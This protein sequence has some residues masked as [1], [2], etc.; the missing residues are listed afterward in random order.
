[1][2]TSNTFYAAGSVITSGKGDGNYFI[3]TNGGVTGDQQDPAAWPDP[4]GHSGEHSTFIPTDTVR[5]NDL[6][7]RYA[8]TAAP[9]VSDKP[10]LWK[11]QALYSLG[12]VIYDPPNASYYMVIAVGKDATQTS[13]RSGT[14]LPNF[15]VPP[16]ATI[17]ENSSASRQ[18]TIMWTDVGAIAPSAVANE[19]PSDQTLSLLNLQ[20]PQVHSLSYY[21]LATGVVIST[22]T[23]RSYGPVGTGATVGT[24]SASPLIE[25]ILMLTVYVHK[26]DAERPHELADLVPAPT[27]GLSL[28]S[29][30]SNYYLGL[31]SEIFRNVQVVGGVNFAKTTKLVGAT[32][33]MT[34][35]LTAQT[36]QRYHIGAYT[37]LTFNFSGF[38]QSLFGGGGKA[39]AAG[40]GQERA[41]ARSLLHV[42]QGSQDSRLGDTWRQCTRRRPT[43]G[44]LGAPCRALARRA[45]GGR[46][47]SLAQSRQRVPFDVARGQAASRAS[48]RAQDFSHCA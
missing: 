2:A 26:L 30:G 10:N 36:A 12:D 29:P 46:L 34:S 39:A 28:V 9:G 44:G 23:S 43:A 45:L 4:A 18:T 3:T 1:V 41:R 32:S 21:N 35:M 6:L 11:P 22:I 7:W 38:V 13:A 15:P 25:P 16:F 42:L 20:L 24:T 5:E 19:Q 33:G 31:A 48:G 14:R 27:F 8:G 17:N 47:E 40:G 37:G